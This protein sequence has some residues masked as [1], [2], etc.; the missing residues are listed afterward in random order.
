MIYFLLLVLA[1]TGFG[2]LC[3]S[4][5][6]HQRDLIGR[7]LAVGMGNYARWSGITILGV[8]FLLSGSHLGWGVGTI[9]W[10]G[11]SS[12]GA[13]VTMAILSRRSMQR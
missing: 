9:E 10:L 8:A 5:E 12:I 3:L 11:L 4:R 1:I 6:R 7:K 2:L 13:V